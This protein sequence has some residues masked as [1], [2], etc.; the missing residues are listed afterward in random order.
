MKVGKLKDPRSAR[1]RPYRPRDREDLEG[2][3]NALAK[4]E[5]LTGPQP[6]AFR[7]MTAVIGK[8]IHV[9]VGVVDG[10]AVGYAIYFFT[11]SSFLC[12]P[13][14]YLEDLFIL[15]GYRRS[16]IGKKFLDRLRKEAKRKKCGRLEW[17]VL[18]WNKPAI[19]FYRKYGAKHLKEWQLF[20]DVL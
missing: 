1:I 15:P 18:D 9:L 6:K 14:L 20:R 8:S 13:T 5:G 3:V 7:R 11:Y 10:R 4:Y 19:S 12:K 16:G 2:L 17:S